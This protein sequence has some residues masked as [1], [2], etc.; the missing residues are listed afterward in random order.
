MFDKKVFVRINSKIKDKEDN[1][2]FY[3]SKLIG[4]DEAKECFVRFEDSVYKGTTFYL[5]LI[6]NIFISIPVSEISN[7]MM[8]P[9]EILEN[10]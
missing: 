8:Y 2:L 10:E 7:L 4:I 6:N 5:E 9:E 1:S 3:D